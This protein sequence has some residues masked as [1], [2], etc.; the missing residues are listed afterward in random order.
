MFADVANEFENITKFGLLD[1]FTRFRDFMQDDYNDVYNYFAGNSETIDSKKL[2]VI[3]NYIS[4]LNNSKQVDLM[5]RF[6]YQGLRLCNWYKLQ[7]KDIC[8]RCMNLIK[9]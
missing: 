1:Y 4:T 2:K 7:L 9:L 5:F 3:F 6:S 8:L